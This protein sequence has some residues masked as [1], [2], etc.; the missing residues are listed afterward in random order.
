MVRKARIYL[1][2]I[3]MGPASLA[4]GGNEA[5]GTTSA[6]FLKIPVNARPAAMGEAF[7]ALSDD[8]SSLSYNPAGLAGILGGDLSATHIEWLQAAHLEHLGGVFRL[9]ERSSAG[10]ALTWLQIDEMARTTRGTGSADPVSQIQY[11][12]TFAPHDML[13]TFGYARELTQDWRVGGSVKLLQQNIDSSN[14]YGVNLDLGGQYLG[15][16]KDLSL[17]LVLRQIGTSVAVGGKSFNMPF[18][19]NV[20]ALYST[21]KN[22]LNLT[23]DTLIALDNQPQSGVGF[24]WWLKELFALRAG[25]RFGYLNSYTV[26]AGFVLRNWKLDYAFVPY[27][28]LGYAHRITAGLSFGSPRIQVTAD[29]P[30]FAPLGSSQHRSTHFLMDAPARQKVASWDLV[31]SDASGAAVRTWSGTGPLAQ[32][33]S[34][35][36]K[37][38]SGRLLPDGKWT[39]TLKAVFPKRTSFSEAASVEIDSSP[40]ELDLDVAPR[41]IQ[42]ENATGAI[43]IPCR[44][45]L[46]AKDIHGVEGWSL[47]ILD[48][49]DRPFRV[50][51][52]VGVPPSELVWD[53]SDGKGE[54]VDSG[55]IYATRFQAVDSLGNSSPGKLVNQVV[56]LREI[57]LKIDDRI[58]FESGKSKLKSGSYKELERIAAAIKKNRGD[59]TKVHIEGHTDN[60]PIHTSEFSDNLILSKARAQALV[61][62]LVKYLGVDG[63]TL[64]AEGFGDSRPVADN[65]TPEGRAVNRRVV[66][67][68]RTKYYR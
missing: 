58:L 57:R 21:L 67:V 60:V 53:G 20:G 10:V 36:G 19:V 6:N 48:D 11:L 14:G 4:F 23:A 24:E 26:G 7:S 39:L 2:W 16:M 62:F 45:K 1:A 46:S 50:F 5:V 41:I 33:W 22:Q 38:D 3:F 54:F 15:L 65:A 27:G 51:K 32:E 37:D 66:V 47:E 61:E 42:P 25:Y 55:R 8:E 56:L 13:L 18:G 63:S 12:G 29:P 35:D 52:G 34:W 30:L 9:G 28:E 68:I 17:G 40:P 44:F 64:E 43:L 31:I 49:R 59:G